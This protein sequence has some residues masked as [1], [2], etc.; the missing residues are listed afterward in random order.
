[1]SPSAK[2][3]AD[4]MLEEVGVHAT[5]GPAA[6]AR[7]IEYGQ[8]TTLKPTSDEVAWCSDCLN[9]I[10]DEARQTHPE[11]DPPTRSAAAISWAGWGE[12]VP[13]GEQDR[14]DVVVF[15][16]GGGHNHVAVYLTEDED[17]PGLIQVVGGNQSGPKGGPH[18]VNEKWDPLNC[19]I[20]FRRPKNYQE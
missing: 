4:L 6:T 2:I 15:D 20:H 8:H 1:M 19:V 5:P 16:W 12:E 14:G 11:I 9:F 17:H 13:D 18:A 7:I 3:I 10:V